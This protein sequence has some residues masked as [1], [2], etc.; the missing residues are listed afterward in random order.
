MLLFGVHGTGP[1][2]LQG[3]GKSMD[4]KNP[5]FEA[6]LPPPIQESSFTLIDALEAY[7]QGSNADLAWLSW[8]DLP[9]L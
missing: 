1:G 7:S 6:N 4:A 9:P 2:H 5:F 8:V 3:K